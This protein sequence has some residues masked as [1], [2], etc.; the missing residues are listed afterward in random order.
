[1][2]AMARI[3]REAMQIELPMQVVRPAGAALAATVAVAKRG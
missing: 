1:M 3:S 2:T